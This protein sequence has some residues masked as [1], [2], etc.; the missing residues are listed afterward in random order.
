MPQSTV[1]PAHTE[2]SLLVVK[3]INETLQSEPRNK[4]IGAD[5]WWL[6]EV[7]GPG[8]WALIL[9]N[10]MEN[11]GVSTRKKFRPT[12]ATLLTLTLIKELKKIKSERKEGWRANFDSIKE[13]VE[14]KGLFRGFL[15][16]GPQ[17][18]S[19][20]CQ[21]QPLFV[22]PL[23]SHHWKAGHP[24]KIL[25]ATKIHTQAMI[26]FLHGRPPEI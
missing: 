19:S 14:K 3:I 21:C 26:F 9:G 12:D 5:L 15:D 17:D 16:P 10:V 25:N 18:P 22:F 20:Q 8:S 7:L 11:K 13:L 23:K 6:L 1:G 24:T 4:Q 2:L